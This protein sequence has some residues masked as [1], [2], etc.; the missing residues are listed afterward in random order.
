MQYSRPWPHF[1]FDNFLS[2]ESI[3]KLQALLHHSENNF[4]QDEDDEMK[5]NYKFLPDLELAKYFLGPEFKTFLEKVTGFSLHLNQKSLVQLRMMTA[6]SPA[7]PPHVDNQDEK[8]LVC[9]LYVSPDWE[10]KYGGELC[11]MTDKIESPLSKKSKIIAPISNRM[12][13]FLSEDSHWHSVMPVKNWIR[14]S[15]IMEWIIT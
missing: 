12:V 11:L 15:I 2:K 13:L 6:E 7:M 4:H 1:V 8:S 5:I 9:I 10:E 14:Y 3:Q